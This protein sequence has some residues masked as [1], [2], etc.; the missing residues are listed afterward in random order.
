MLIHMKKKGKT[1]ICPVC[2]KKRRKVIE[3]RNRIIRDKN[4]SEEKCFISL[5]TYR[6]IC[7]RSYRG[8]EKLDFILPGERFT[9][10]FANY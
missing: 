4:I 5:K 3:I 10:R 1:G 2:N 9:D 6:I 7:K 8:M